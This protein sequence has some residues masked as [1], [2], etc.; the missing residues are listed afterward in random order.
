MNVSNLQCLTGKFL[1]YWITSYSLYM[2]Y[3]KRCHS[4][5]HVIFNSFCLS[6]RDRFT[7]NDTVGTIYLN[8]SKISAS[9]GEVE[10]IF[11]CFCLATGTHYG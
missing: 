9:G 1:M 4:V 11:S 8:L 5:C 6:G 3:K 7:S 2:T 10:G